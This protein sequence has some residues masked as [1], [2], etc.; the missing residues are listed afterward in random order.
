MINWSEEHRVSPCDFLFFALK[1]L[2]IKEAPALEESVQQ[3]FKIFLQEAEPEA[4]MT[5]IEG[6]AL[7]VGADLSNSQYQKL[8]R[9]KMVGQV[10]PSLVS[11]TKAKDMLDPGNFEYKVF[12]KSGGQEVEHHRAT[13]AS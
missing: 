7:K 3:V 4:S 13:L 2:I 12:H 6:L 5:P 1:R 9:N 8:R 10:I 11:V